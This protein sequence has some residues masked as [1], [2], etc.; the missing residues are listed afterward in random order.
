MAVGQLH[1]APSNRGGVLDSGL[2]FTTQV[3]TPIHPR[4]FRR[5]FSRLT[6]QA[7]LGRWHPN[8]LRHSTVSPLSPAGV[9]EEDAADLV[10][11]TTT[12]MTHQVYRRQV[13]PTITAGRDAMERMFG[14]SRPR[15][16]TQQRS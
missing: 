10:G 6:E 3:G 9:R 1:R 13:T 7:G 12:R 5:S 4:N 11:H 8:E 2:V 15:G 14:T 16:R